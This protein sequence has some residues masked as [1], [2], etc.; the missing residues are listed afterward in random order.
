MSVQGGFVLISKVEL[1]LIQATEL[2]NAHNL[3]MLASKWLEQG[4]CFTAIVYFEFYLYN[5]CTLR[6]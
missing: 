5:I 3:A 6:A 4:W 1:R 2:L